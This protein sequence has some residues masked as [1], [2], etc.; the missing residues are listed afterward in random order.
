MCTNKP[1]YVCVSMYVCKYV[2]TKLN[3]LTV[4]AKGRTSFPSAP[5]HEFCQPTRK[6]STDTN[7]V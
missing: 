4:L 6:N 7:L 1:I 3:A 2:I 5:I